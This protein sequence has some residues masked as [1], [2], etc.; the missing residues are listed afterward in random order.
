MVVGSNS[1]R[2]GRPSSRRQGWFSARR[3]IF[4]SVI[5]LWLVGTVIRLG[6]RGGEKHTQSKSFLFAQ[7]QETHTKNNQ[8]LSHG[9]Q[10]TSMAQN[11]P[12]SQ[13]GLLGAEQRTS[14]SSLHHGSSSGKV[15][16]EA[17]N[18]AATPGDSDA[19]K[20]GLI[21]PET[22]TP[23]SLTDSAGVSDADG[24][25]TQ[26]RM[27]IEPPVVLERTSIDTA[28]Q[29]VAGTQETRDELI[30]EGGS[31]STPI[32]QTARVE[33]S[34]QQGTNT[35]ASNTNQNTQDA[36]PSDVPVADPS[37]QLPS[38]RADA[39]EDQHNS[40]VPENTHTGSDNQ[41]AT[42]TP[43]EHAQAQ[44]DTQNGDQA[45]QS[46]NSAQA[47]ANTQDVSSS[48]ETMNATAYDNDNTEFGEAVPGSISN[49]V[50]VQQGDGFVAMVGN[51]TNVTWQDEADVTAGVHDGDGAQLLQ[52]NQ[53][54]EDEIQDFARFSESLGVPELNC[55]TPR[56]QRQPIMLKSGA[57]TAWPIVSIVTPALGGD[58]LGRKLDAFLVSVCRQTVLPAQVVIVLSDAP[59]EL[60][61]R[62]TLV[63][64]DVFSMAV[65]FIIYCSEVKLDQARA[66]NVGTSIAS[67]EVCMLM[68]GDDEMH[69]QRVEFTSILFAQNPGLKA[70]AHAGTVNHQI[71]TTSVVNVTTSTGMIRTDVDMAEHLRTKMQK[72]V[73]WGDALALEGSSRALCKGKCHITKGMLP[74]ASV[75]LKSTFSQVR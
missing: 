15:L 55:T 18:S 30:R 2:P 67:G 22:G 19:A 43:A 6:T 14:S 33:E 50:L 32:P 73:M 36:Q 17:G 72:R 37:M 65:S 48:A 47:A 71:F 9:E 3:I 62:I 25:S 53:S 29:Q 26:R 21:L 34:T 27:Q 23:P 68:D 8:G 24:G 54:T 13:V 31:E 58:V 16:L 56:P 61:E 74:G 41:D 40:N 52:Y 45:P 57:M 11:V 28:E 60:C 66:R 75:G 39:P 5:A 59:P 7:G 1:Q 42:A 20:E 49:Q 70:F 35:D 10:V 38:G 51:D 12:Q 4:V 44:A 46:D 63:A 69:Y 64:S